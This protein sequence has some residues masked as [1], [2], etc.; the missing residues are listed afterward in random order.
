MYFET[1]KSPEELLCPVGTILTLGE[2]AQLTEHN[3]AMIHM[4]IADADA[5]RITPGFA[6]KVLETLDEAGR[7]TPEDLAYAYSDEDES[8]HNRDRDGPI[9]PAGRM[10]QGFPPPI[11]PLD[12]LENLLEESEDDEEEGG[13]SRF[14]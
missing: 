13:G 6:F 5:F 10:G 14:P 2:V 3:A 1:L 8:H 11:G 9:S 7:I 12:P 4:A